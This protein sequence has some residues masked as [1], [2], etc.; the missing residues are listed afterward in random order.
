MKKFNVDVD[1]TMSK[2]IEVEAE[3]EEQAV[4][5]ADA[6][7]NDNPY[8]YA[9]NFSHFVSYEVVCANEIEED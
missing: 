7:M 4:K 8:Q 9:N 6:L 2:S 1:V 5:I 3:S